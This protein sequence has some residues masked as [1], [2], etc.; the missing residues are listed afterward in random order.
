MLGRRRRARRL[1]LR[2]T[3]PVAVRLIGENEHA[4]E[5]V[6][7]ALAAAEVGW[8]D[9]VHWVERAG[10]ECVEADADMTAADLQAAAQPTR[11]SDGAASAAREVTRAW[12]VGVVGSHR[13]LSSAMA[14]VGGSGDAA[15]WSASAKTM[16][17]EVERLGETARHLVEADG[18]DAVDDAVGKRSARDGGRADRQP[19]SRVA[20]R[21]RDRLWSHLGWVVLFLLGLGVAIGVFLSSNPVRSRISDATKVEISGPAH[22]D[23]DRVMALMQVETIPG[24]R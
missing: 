10:G 1:Q 23:T 12:R 19:S 7:E 20:A 13:D 24:T 6:V 18:P 4:L 11:V 3:G 2:R 17:T 9:C 5:V 15:G 14:T 22:C 8:R 16:A 21:A